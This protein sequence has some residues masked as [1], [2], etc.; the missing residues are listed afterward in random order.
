MKAS[1]SN[2]ALFIS[3]LAPAPVVAVP[4]VV[5]DI[6]VTHSLVATV[7]GAAG[8]PV[9]LMRSGASP[10]DYALRPSDA[11]IL[12]QADVVIWTSASL[13]PWLPKAMSTLAPDLPSVEL[14]ASP[15]TLHLALRQSSD[16]AEQ[17]HQHDEA[18][19]GIDPHAW[20]DPVNAQRWLQTIA[21]TLTALDPQHGVTYQDNAR[22]GI[23]ALADL[24]TRLAGRLQEVQGKPYIVF[25][26]SYRYLEERFELPAMA[27]ISLGDGT[28]PGIR[29]INTLRKLLAEHPGA[30]VF[31]EPQFSERL[32]DTVTRGLDARRGVLDPLGSTLEPGSALY[33]QLMEKL[34]LTMHACLSAVP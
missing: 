24:G 11:T 23:T 34:T 21:D 12:G 10:H 13:T 4:V 7:M 22:R 32:V 3:L 29:Q 14:L 1:L 33:I 26:D 27:T 19:Q 8:E 18:E 16:F 20:L 9:L 2:F 17:T 28:L 15:G 31:A 6:P 25:H 5:T 30:C